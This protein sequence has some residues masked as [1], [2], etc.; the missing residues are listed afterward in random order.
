MSCSDHQLHKNHV[1]FKNTMTLQQFI[2][3]MHTR[4][5]IQLQKENRNEMSSLQR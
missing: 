1:D 5:N 4:Q 3:V 2:L